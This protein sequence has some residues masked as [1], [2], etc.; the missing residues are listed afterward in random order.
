MDLK[1]KDFA[2]A[3]GVTDSIIYRHI[4]AH[5]EALGENV[6][7]QGKS[8]WLTDAGQ[9]YIKDLMIKQ[10]YLVSDTGINLKI[11]ELE[12]E[13]NRL[14]RE[15]AALANEK[16][17]FSEKAGQVTLLISQSAE[18]EKKIEELQ[19]E[20]TAQAVKIGEISALSAEK[21][22]SIEELKKQLT[23]ATEA[24]ERMKNASP[25]A[26]LLKKF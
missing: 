15:N 19:A 7:K 22:K 10:P 8:T 3:Q 2:A 13:N 12:Q 26:R 23:E 4:R 18:K 11:Y 25:L 6:Y 14:Y 16:A 21:D 1:V 20:N 17:A 9:A 24:V 5:K